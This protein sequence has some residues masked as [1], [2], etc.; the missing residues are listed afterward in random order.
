MKHSLFVA[1][2]TTAL[3]LLAGG[4]QLGG[5][6]SAP[7]DK[8]P[9]T[10]PPARAARASYANGLAACRRAQGTDALPPFTQYLHGDYRE[11]TARRYLDRMRSIVRANLKS[12][13]DVGIALQGC[14]EGAWHASAMASA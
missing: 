7:E 11:V 9:T 14:L 3:A 6:S 8:A 13:N 12:G 1:A 10:A 2:R 4:C 5:S